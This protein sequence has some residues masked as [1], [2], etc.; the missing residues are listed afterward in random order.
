MGAWWS[1][2]G[3][4]AK[5]LIVIVGFF[6]V[7][8]VING[9]SNGGDNTTTTTGATV[10]NATDTTQTTASAT[11][12][13]TTSTT[14]PPST[15]TEPE[16][17][18]VGF[19]AGM[20]KVGADIPA[21]EYVLIAGAGS[22]Y[23]QITKDSS[24]T[25]ESIVANDNFSN[26]SIVTLKDGQYITSNDARLVPSAQAVPAELVDG[27]LPEGMYRVGFDLPAGEYKVIPDGSGYF[28]IDS[29]SS[30]TL[31]GIISNENF[32]TERYVTVK[33]GQYLKL[34][35]ASVVVK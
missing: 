22:A 24:G 33:D 10:A 7:I 30:H 12:Q 9:I 17:K 13:S 14:E 25:L 16:P 6:V 21:G 32:D 5:T 4:F 35:G 18:E 2:R 26:Q 3:K 19:D 15:T 11:T 23:F 27:R 28:E 8:A 1:K 31:E 34:S 29:N 20:Y